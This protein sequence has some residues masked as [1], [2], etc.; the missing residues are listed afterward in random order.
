MYRLLLLLSSFARLK[1]AS[2]TSVKQRL[3]GRNAYEV[4]R[5]KRCNN[6]L[7]MRLFNKYT[8]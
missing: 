3:C 2:F 5:L 4:S 1:K 8:T 7:N 6:C